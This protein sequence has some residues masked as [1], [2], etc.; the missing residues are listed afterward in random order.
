MHESITWAAAV[1]VWGTIVW[2]ILDW[3][4]ISSTTIIILAVLLLLDYIF[5]VLD[6]YLLDK[7]KITSKKW[8]KWIIKKSI[9]LSLPFIVVAILRG[10]GIEETW[11]ITNSIITIL[12]FNEWYSIIG[13]ILSI[14]QGKK[15][16]EIDAFEMLCKKIAKIFEEWIDKD[17]S[18]LGEDE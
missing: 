7:R 12:C 17:S 6:A 9:R 14:D 13:H 2:G 15:L 4:W 3:F 5:W 16:P 10:W 18:S 8:L 11:W 1:V